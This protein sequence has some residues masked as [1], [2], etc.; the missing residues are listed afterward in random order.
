MLTDPKKDVKEESVIDVD[1]SPIRKK[2]FRI[3]GDDEKILELNVSDLNIFVRL[4]DAYPKLDKLAHDA[5]E[6]LPDED[7]DVTDLESTNEIAKTLTEIDSEMRNLLDYIFDAP[8][9]EVC[10]SEG[11]MYDPFGG[12]L[13]YEHILETLSALYE[14]NLNAEVKKMTQRVNKHTAK[15]TKSRAKK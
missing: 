11:S 8:V 1:L 3:N 12:K 7:A 2:R 5:I 13:R 15:Y 10:A 14:N 9:S 6:K 4:N